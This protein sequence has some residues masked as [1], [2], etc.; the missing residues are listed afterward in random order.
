MP[1]TWF[2]SRRIASRSSVL[3]SGYL[4]SA[5]RTA[6]RARWANAHFG[7]RRTPS[8]KAAI[9]ST[10]FPS[11]RKRTAEIH[12][13]EPKVRC[14]PNRLAALRDRFIVIPPRRQTPAEVACTFRDTGIQ[15]NR[16]RRAVIASSRCPLSQSELP[17][18][19]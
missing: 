15:P 2:G 14:Q 8:R 12:V 4:P 13:G 18:S 10:A 1:S 7:S 19:S 16:G 17:S 6:P 11:V 9:P 5:A 3:A